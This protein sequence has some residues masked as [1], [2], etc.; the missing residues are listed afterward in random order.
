MRRQAPAFFFDRKKNRGNDF[1]RFRAE[2]YL[3][4]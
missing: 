1:D 2:F 3:F 4:D